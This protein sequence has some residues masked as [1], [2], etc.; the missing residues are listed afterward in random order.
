MCT[1][2]STEGGYI[3]CQVKTTLKT[4]SRAGKLTFET[5]LHT[6]LYPH[7]TGTPVD[8]GCAPSSC[9]QLAL[10]HYHTRT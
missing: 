8:S 7:P 5:V 6:L 2:I 4:W 10:I 1:G 3:Y 9:L